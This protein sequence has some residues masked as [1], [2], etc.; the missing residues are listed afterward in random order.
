M[1]H[2]MG[3]LQLEDKRE[4][5]LLLGFHRS[6]PTAIENASRV[7]HCQDFLDFM[8]LQFGLTLIFSLI[9]PPA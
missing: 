7:R 3:S 5:R 4:E 2:S 6:S 1:L 9:V 8:M